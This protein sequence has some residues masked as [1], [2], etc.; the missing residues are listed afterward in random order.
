PSG[1]VRPSQPE[2]DARLLFLSVFPFGA[3]SRG[4]S[5]DA[6]YPV[7]PAMPPSV[8]T[9]KP[10]RC[11]P[12]FRFRATNPMFYVRRQESSNVSSSRTTRILARRDD[13]RQQGLTVFLVGPADG[14][15]ERSKTV[16]DGTV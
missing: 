11:K 9:L 3:I 6:G 5:A 16:S 12:R 1:A 8:T 7:K 2:C 15:A 14:A 4:A 10:W 13:T